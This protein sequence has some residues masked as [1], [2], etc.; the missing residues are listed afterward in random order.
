MRIIGI[1]NESI[2]LGLDCEIDIQRTIQMVRSQRSGMVQTEAQYKFVYLAV[3]HHIE[4][5]TER[6]KENQV[7]G[8]YIFTI[9]PQLFISNYLNFLHSY[10]YRLVRVLII[11]SRNACKWVENTLILGTVVI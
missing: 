9:S 7:S 8:V 10:F 6:M 1:S 4:T 3:Q 5:I 2:C 11:Y